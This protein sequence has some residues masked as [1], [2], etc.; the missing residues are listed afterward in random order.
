MKSTWINLKNNFILNK[1]I[2]SIDTV[3]SGCKIDFIT[4]FLNQIR[5]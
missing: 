1:I 5:Y 2:N 3:M 4:Q